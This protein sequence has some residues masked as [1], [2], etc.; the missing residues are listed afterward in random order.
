VIVTIATA[1]TIIITTDSRITRP[2]SRF[3]RKP[4]A[5]EPATL[6]LAPWPASSDR[7]TGRGL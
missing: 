2:D 5:P 7:E 6:A 3:S 1:T 4:T